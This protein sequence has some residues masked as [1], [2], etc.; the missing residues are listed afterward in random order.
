L[1]PAKVIAD[2]AVTVVNATAA[3]ARSDPDVT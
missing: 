1:N 3:T 2:A